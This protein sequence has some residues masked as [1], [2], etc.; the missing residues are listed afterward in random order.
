[1]TS[2]IAVQARESH[3]E[4]QMLLEMAKN[5]EHVIGVVGWVDLKDPK[6]ADSLT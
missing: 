4:N 6:V 5:N 1:M 3:E 2:S